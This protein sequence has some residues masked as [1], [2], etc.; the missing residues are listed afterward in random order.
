M[1]LKD[2]L[3]R[4]VELVRQG[5]NREHLTTEIF[6][7]F[8]G[9]SHLYEY[10]IAPTANGPEF[11]KV[12]APFRVPK[13]KVQTLTGFID[14]IEAGIAGEPGK[15]GE[16]RIVHVADHLNVLLKTKKSDYFGVRDVL[17]H[18]EHTPAGA[19]EFDKYMT[20]EIF[21]I[22]LQTQFLFLEGDDALYLQRVVSNLKTGDSVHAQDDGVNTSVTLKVGQVESAEHVLKSRVKLTPIRT[23]AEAAPVQAEFLLRLKGQ[24]SNQLPLVALYNLGGIKWQNDA[25]LSIKKY[26]E[27]HLPQGLPVLA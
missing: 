16:L 19:F 12:I 25:M 11:G 23:F 24:G 6:Q 27:D 14:A 13:L 21:L 10:A 1:D 17:V 3:N 26:L 8:D 2:T 5:D 18:A 4:I 7:D 15:L 9:E 20:P 22:Q